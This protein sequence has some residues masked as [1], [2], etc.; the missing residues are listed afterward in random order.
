VHQSCDIRGA[1]AVAPVPWIGMASKH[2]DESPG[3]HHVTCRGNNKRS[4]YEDVD[5]RNRFL[6]MLGRVA[7]RY[8]WKIHAYC[9]MQNHYHLVIEIDERGMSRGFC[10]LHTGYARS[11]NKRHGRVNHLF[12]KRYWSARVEDDS[13]FL[14]TCR[15]V[16]RNPVRAGLVTEV[17]RWRWSSYRATLGLAG[18]NLPLAVD[19]LL[20]AFGRQRPGAL[21]RFREFVSGPLAGRR[22]WQPP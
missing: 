3:I 4:I 1:R 5:D 17:A 15:Y 13:G 19:E 10:E 20:A 7:S 6:L 8:G 2:R 21:D 9:L 14:N 12:G 22:R 18:T 16:L 11:Y